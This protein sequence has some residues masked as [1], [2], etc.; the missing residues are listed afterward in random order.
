MKCAPLLVLCSFLFL[1]CGAAAP[2]PKPLA[3]FSAKPAMQGLDDQLYPIGWS[4]DGTN[5]AILTEKL[6]EAADEQTWTLDI[7]DLKTDKPAHSQPFRVDV[8]TPL[9]KFWDQHGPAIEALL[10][11]H[12]IR[13]NAFVLAPFPGLEGKFRSE[14]L[15]ISLSVDHGQEPNFEYTGVRSAQLNL[16]RAST[17][18]KT[19]F[20]KTWKQWY[21]LALGAI[22]YLPNPAGDRIAIVVARTDRGYEGPPHVRRLMIVGAGIGSKF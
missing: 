21:P 19:V 5:L 1:P 18:S 22:G 9:A 17:E 15:E 8:E 7:L 3:V 12:K 16:A 2:P 10:A 13:R 14:V 20:S 11:K 4:A 6:N